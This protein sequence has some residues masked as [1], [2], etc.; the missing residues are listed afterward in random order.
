MSG[1]FSFS[2]ISVVGL[3]YIGLP[4]AALF[5]SCK[6]QVIGLDINQNT[7][8]VVN[9][10]KIHI[11]GPGLE[12]IVRDV[13]SDGYLTATCIPECADVFLIA[14]PTPFKSDHQPDLSYIQSAASAIAPVLKAGNLVILEST[15]PVGATEQLEI[16]L[17]TAR[18]DLSFPSLRGEHSDIRM[19]Y[20]PERVL[21]GKVLHELIENDRIIGGMTNLC[22]DMAIALYQLFVKG[23]CVAT[24]TR[25]AEMCKLTENSFRDVNLAFANE[26][27]MICDKLDIDEFELIRLA[28]RHPRVNILQPG[29]GVGGHCIPVDPWFIVSSAPEHA[30]LIAAARDVND[31]KP[32]WF[33]DKVQASITAFLEDNPEK[34]KKDI[35][36]ACFGLAFKPDIDDLRKSPAL[37]IVQ[38][39]GAL[40][41]GP[42]LIVEPHIH[43]LPESL[44]KIA[45]LTDAESALAESDIIL[46]LV[47]HSSF[48]DLPIQK[49]L[50]SEKKY[51]L[52]DMRGCD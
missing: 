30:K 45:N 41:D 39:L 50:S 9:Q 25:T 36:I 8:E 34:L 42:I 28:N 7:V 46:L 17:A 19:A 13:V 52:I 3:G 6:K 22:S 20:C 1:R 14:V 26:I 18:P 2:K 23:A 21:P 12:V 5:A 4:T 31:S 38:K 37:Y 29:I 44:M 27:S 47:N 40:Y 48:K 51:K 15:S 16:W 35:T 43:I 49:M 10:G 32:E 33:L 11:S 24:T